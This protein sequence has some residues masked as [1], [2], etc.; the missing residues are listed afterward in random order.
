MLPEEVREP[1]Q[2]DIRGLSKPEGRALKYDWSGWWARPAQLPPDGDHW[3]HWGLVAG[4]GFGK[5]RT[6][7][8][9]IRHRVNQ[10]ARSI[11]LLAENPGDARDVMIDGNEGSS[12]LEVFPPHQ[13]PDYQPSKARIVFH[14]GAVARIFSSHKPDGPRGWQGDTY[15]ADEVASWKYPEETWNNMM[16]G[17][18]GEALRPRGVFTTTPKPIDLLR[19]LM[20]DGQT[21][22]TRGSTYENRA[23]LAE[24][25]FQHVVSKYEGTQL[26]Q[27][28]L[29]G[30]LL[31]EREGA[32]WRRKWID[33]VQPDDVPDFRE[34]VVGV[35]PAG[36]TGER[37]AE[38][39]I[40]AAG[41][42]LCDCK[43]RAGEAD[44]PEPHLF[45]LEDRSGRL[46]PNG[47]ARAAVD[48]YEELGAGKLIGEQN[49]GGDMVKAT[50]RNVDG[51]KAVAYKEV[52]ASRGKETRAAPISALY[53]QG[54]AHHVGVHEQLEG[55]MVTWVPDEGPSPDRIDALVWAASQLF[56]P[57]AEPAKRSSS[58]GTVG[59]SLGM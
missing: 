25:F 6:G 16:F 22:L 40:V 27:Q 34:V 42:A 4:R 7:A 59:R 23:N 13:E 32:L 2:E 5:T 15:W 31:E 28:E 47:W 10:G 51:G 48:L 12:I 49:N 36:S 11:A 24:A 3:T 46:T 26:G 17:L 30:V 41:K 19:E 44:Q 53:E 29:L 52:Y 58:T 50:V 8:E 21:E 55:Q 18:R 20:D 1:I 54:K 35:D 39:G 43:V 37:S 38:T 57:R 33:H 9:Y 14:T 56:P 45:V